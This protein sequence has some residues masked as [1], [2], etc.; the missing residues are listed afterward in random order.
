MQ[1]PVSARAKTT[2]AFSGGFSQPRKN[3]RTDS[4]A[5]VSVIMAI[6]EGH[7]TKAFIHRYMYVITNHYS[8]RRVR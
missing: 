4:E 6:E 7:T 8:Y 1:T 2:T 3:G 5:D